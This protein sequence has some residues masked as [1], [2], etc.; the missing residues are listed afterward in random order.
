MAFFQV[1]DEQVRQLQEDGFF[2]VRRLF[3]QEETDLLN[4]IAKTDVDMKKAH[5]RRDS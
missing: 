2:V 4:K 5:G 3:E 1:S